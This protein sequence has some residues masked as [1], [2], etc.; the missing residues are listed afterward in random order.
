MPIWG[1]MLLLACNA[2]SGKVQQE[3]RE[4]HTYTNQLI[5]ESS[6][7]LL[8][9]A[10]NPVNWHPWNEAALQKAKEE[11]KMLIISVGY[12]ACHWCHVMEQESFEDTAVARI[13][14]EYFIPI[15]VD[16]EER[17]DVDDVY[18]TAC[19]LVSNRSCGWPL[20]A[21]ALPSGQPVWA[22]TYFPKKQWLEVLTYFQKL[23]EEEPLKL[24]EYAQQ[25]TEGIQQNSEIGLN[26]GDKE[27]TAAAIQ[28]ITANF[29]NNIDFKKGGRKNP[30]KFPMPS[31]YEFLL[32]YY[33]LFKDK[34]A[35]EAATVTLDNIAMGGIYDH[36]GGGF[37]RYSTDGDWK[38]PHFEKMMYDNGQLVSLYSKAY[39]VTQNP[40]YRQRVEETL[41]WVKREMTSAEGG[42]YSSLD[43]D[44][45]GEEGKFYVWTKLELD[46][47]LADSTLARLFNDYYEVTAKG[48]WEHQKNILYRIKSRE[49]IAQKHQI[50]EKELEEMIAKTKT[51]LLAERSK[52]VRPGLD[53]KI[54]TSWNALMLKGYVDAYKAFGKKD[55][56]NAALRNGEFLLKNMLQKDHRLN[57]NYKDGKSVINAFLDDYALSIEAFMALYEVTFDEKYLYQARDL[58]DY[59]IAH[60]FDKKS[61]MFF[62][63]SDVDPPL[64]TRRM[65]TSDNVIPGSN[66]VMA[67]NLYYLGLY[68]YNE[69]YLEKAKQMMHNITEN[70]VGN[71]QPNFYSNWLNLYID[72]VKPTFEI[73]VVGDNFKDKQ[74]A[75]LMNYMPDAILLGGKNEGTLELLKG[76]LQEGETMIY[77]C[78]NKV[79]K[80]PVSKVEKA[81]E[82]LNRK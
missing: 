81:V 24:E 38:V 71:P 6:P 58:A 79:C 28:D 76:K 7:Y 41:D 65:E 51:K 42:F 8:Q 43:A 45:E 23:K 77:V 53:D 49:E 37:A 19:H 4:K 31:N 39:L 13:M 69:D 70:V 54:L 11:D 10:H 5:D 27:F 36:L 56:L 26:L 40:I 21:F 22:G 73:A 68:F 50:S 66:S 44:S 30:P 80:L 20:N 82:L 9:H 62:Y 15:K 33:H 59:A 75:L 47:L 52:R 29:L 46:S 2:H 25:I 17:P 63:T 64:I 48:N 35:L 16:R 60:F 1:L 12:A 3:E 61:G 72:L 34:K 55:Y 57:R 78:Q 14:N 74:R 18:M 32:K 67:R